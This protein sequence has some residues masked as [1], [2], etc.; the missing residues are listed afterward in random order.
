MDSV[1]IVLSFL[2]NIYPFEG[3]RNTIKAAGA[4][5]ARSNFV[6][7]CLG[8]KYGIQGIPIEWIERIEGMEQII[9]NSL[10]CFSKS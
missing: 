7:A 9:E 8:A 6:G 10:K 2:E 4:L 5:C 1:G 3:I